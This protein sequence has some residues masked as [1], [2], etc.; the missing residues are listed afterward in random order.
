MN[1]TPPRSPADD[2]RSAIRNSRAAACRESGV[3]ERLRSVGARHGPALHGEVA[4]A[5]DAALSSFTERS[6]AR[7]QAILRRYACRRNLKLT[8]E[9]NVEIEGAAAAG[10][11]AVRFVHC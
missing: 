10:A 11:R 4:I 9:E 3:V 8:S 7:K 6:S 1:P 5:W 2:V